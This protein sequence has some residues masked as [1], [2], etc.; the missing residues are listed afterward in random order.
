MVLKTD[1]LDQ[2]EV[3]R[4]DAAASQ[5]W[6]PS[7]DFAPLHRLAQARLTFIRDQLVENASLSGARSDAPS[8]DKSSPLVG[9]SIVDVGCGGGLVTEPLARMGANVSGIDP[10]PGN[11]GAAQAHAR[12]EGLDIDYNAITVEALAET[13]ATFDAV[14]CLEVL[15]HVPDPNAF[16][17]S[18][19]QILKPGGLLITSTINRT[20]KSYALAIVAAE[21]IFD[22]VPRGTHDW[23]RFIRPNDLKTM[24]SDCG[25]MPVKFEGMVLEPLANTWR[26]AADTDVNYIASAR[27]TST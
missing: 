11:I 1:N 24:L 23:N 2:A 22:I 26:L 10:G 13:S 19:A 18:C 16:L 15:E 3:S 21:Y 8:H 9:L 14:L 6:N 4:F 12:I 7:G 27:K 25:L 17:Q 5:W 20:M